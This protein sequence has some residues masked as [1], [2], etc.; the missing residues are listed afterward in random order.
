MTERRSRLPDR[1][2]NGSRRC[3]WEDGKSDVGGVAC[4]ALGYGF[5]YDPHKM[6][7]DY[8]QDDTLFR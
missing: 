7:A 2:G 3:D 4:T 8:V 6:A 5:Q 1:N